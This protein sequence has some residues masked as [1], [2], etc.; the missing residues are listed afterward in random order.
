MIRPTT[1]L[2]LAVL[3]VR[4][5]ASSDCVVTFNEI[6]Y[7]PAGTSEAGEYVEL[8]NQ[9]GIKTD[10]SGWRIDGIGYTFP[11]NTIVNPGTYIVVAKTPGAGQ[12]GPFT[13]SI[14]NNGQRLRLINH[15]DRL[16]DEVDFADDAPWPAG[17]DGSGFTLAK[18]LPYADSGRHASWTVSVQPGGTPGA[19][20]F[21]DAGAPPPVTTVNL[22]NLDNTW[23]FNQNGPAL[24]ATWA[25]TAHAVGGTG[26]NLWESGTGAI[27]YETSATVPIGKTLRFPGLNSPYVVTYYFETEFNVTAAQLSSIAALKIRHALDDG[28]VIYIN[29][30]EATR[31]GMPGG[32]IVSSTL[33]S[34][35]A[36]EAGTSLS[37]YVP[38][39]TTALVAGTNRLSVEV[40]QGAIGNSDIVWGAQLDMDT[41][42]AVPG[43]AP[44]LRLN[45]IPAAT[46]AAWWVEIVNTGAAPVD[47]AGV[48]VNAGGDAARD[49]A[50]PSGSLAGGAVLLLSEATL[51][52][53]PADGEKV[54]LFTSG[55]SALMDARQQ[56]GRLRGRAESRGGEWAYPSAA[57]PG[58]ANAFVFNDSVVIN[59]IMYNPPALAP[60]PA[61]PPTFQSDP[62]ISYGD[63]WRYNAADE[64]LPANWAAT[65]HPAGGNWLTGASPIGVESSP[66]PVPLAT[67]LTPYVQATVTYYFERDFT[68]TAQQLATATSLEITHMIDDGA[69][70]YLNGVEIPSSRF[71]MANGAVTPETLASTGVDNAVLNSLVLPVSG[72]IAGSNRLSVEVHQGSTGSSDMVFGLKLDARVQLTPGTPGQPL[73]N[74][75]NQWLELT[76]RGPAAVNLTGWD[77]EDGLT[78]SFPAGTMLAPGE[79]ACVV[80]D[81]AAFSAAHPSARVL[82][83]FTGSLSRT[84]EHIV[85]RD[86][87]RNTAD[88]VRY[89]DSGRWPEFADGGG[90]SLEL[91]DPDSD[92]MQSGAWAASDEGSRTAWR[93]YTYTATAAASNGG[94]DGQWNEFNM[95]LMAAGEIWIDDISVIENPGGTSVQKIADGAFNNAAAWRRRGNHRASQVIPEPGNPGN[96]IL[97]LVATGPTEHMHNQIET[98][99]AGTI[100]NGQ[101]YQVSFR[102]RWVAGG[103]QLHTRCYFNRLARVNVIDRVANPGTPGAENSRRVANAGPTFSGLKHSPPVPA[104]GEVTVVSCTASDPDGIGVL[105]LF[106][107]VNGGSW[108]NTAMSTTGGGLY[109]GSIPGQVAGAVVQFYVRGTDA[110]GA[111]EFYPA[112]GPDSRALYKVNDG[113]AATNGLHNFRVITTNADRDWMHTPINVMSNDRIECTIIDRENDIYY[114][115]GVRLKSSERG[116]N[117][118]PR[119]GYN[120]DFPS[121]ALFRGTLGG[122]A[123]DRSEGVNS[124]QQE[125]LYDVMI[126]NSGGPVSRYFDL[127]KILSPNSALTR[128]AVLQLARYDDV[129]LDS[130]YENGSEGRLFEYELVYYPTSADAS[131]NKLPQPDGV[132]GVNVTNH[133]DDQERYRWH[134]LN[135]INREA[136]DF[137]PIMNYC[138]LFNLSGAA[139]ETALAERVDVDEW[140]RG[141]AYAVLSGAGDNAAAGSQHNGIYY[142]KPDGRVVFLPHDMDFSFSTTRSITSNPDCNTFV[143]TSPARRRL[144]YGHLHDIITTTYNNSYMSIWTSHFAT[145]DPAQPWSSHLSYMNSRSSNVLSQITSGIPQI[146]FAITTASPLTVASSTAT[147]NGNGWVN[148]RS[149]RIQGS[150]EPL[151]VTWTGNSTWQTTV[152]VP[153]GQS[154]V[155]LEAVNFSGAVIGT[156]NITVNNTTQIVPASPDNLVVS[157]IM[158]HPSDPTAAENIA[159]YTDDSFFEYVELQNISAAVLDLTGVRFTAGI[160]YAFAAGTQL[161]PGARITVP[162]SRAAFLMR[163]PG[164]AATLAAGEFNNGTNLNNAGEGLTLVSAA[165][166]SIKD[167]SYDDNPPWPTAPDGAGYSLV[168][169]NPAGNPDHNLAAN[170]RASAS[171]GGNPGSSDAVNLTGNP[172]DDLD[173]D[174]QDAL[175]EHGLGTSDAVAGQ[176]AVSSVVT[177]DGHLTVTYQRRLA[178]DDVIVEPQI[179][180]DMVTWDAG[181]FS[182]VSETPLDDGTATVVVRSLAPAPDGRAFVRVAVRTR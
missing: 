30:Q 139:F 95:G 58:A 142:A 79:F 59:E 19:I 119:V 50:I 170:W 27:A 3:A 75:D 120:I 102:A 110:P 178:A 101:S 66:L 54:F 148:V 151:S 41:F 4:A 176:P 45:E 8:F 1:A 113:A 117:E 181:A 87:L 90:T 160:D 46:E 24:D 49:Y 143:S 74:S 84:G 28:A 177:P 127:I 99:L 65:A 144:Y 100:S 92:N 33:A 52:F 16:M 172:G 69:I 122:V 118:V 37:S 67:V 98:T 128:T 161:Q 89:Y 71:G 85:L 80:R 159:G 141:M 43:A 126:S 180:S 130:Q 173:H 23:R 22:F 88:E 82:G 60:V 106:Y 38:L 93:T 132:I 135:K 10:I 86:A 31:I 108:L 146:A 125:I 51:G 40:H 29:G 112:A 167:F 42:D 72:L 164:A 34:S 147:L 175:L 163:Y 105:T 179:S 149:I 171:T 134:F 9:M 53:R 137:A 14:Q 25:Q 11:P 77:F 91:R 94:P 18:R 162:S 154:T 123:V 76:N 17:A 70:F 26:V 63:T 39:P 5:S 138:K 47:L 55:K 115:A 150:T 73:R 152:P 35:A 64:N 56:T 97:R 36:V 174:G 168:L 68:V 107:S 145:L 182:L 166:V 124:G 15:S 61:L 12:F 165:G 21:P 109:T 44:P 78:F 104:A 83:T 62:L 48:I 121:D 81:P 129:F 32:A 13:G 155:T 96:N 57:T 136:D 7:N 114:G 111:A 157:E 103:N 20:N 6:Q 169:I 133:G 2:S 116:R 158:Y 156:A 153:P 131:G 140:L